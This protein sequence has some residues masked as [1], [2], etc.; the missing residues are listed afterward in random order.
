MRN[1]SALEL[2][3]LRA[4]LVD[5]R[6]RLQAAVQAGIRFKGQND[7]LIRFLSG[8]AHHGD[9]ELVV[10]EA[11]VQAAADA[12][13]LRFTL[14]PA[15]GPAGEKLLVLRMVPKVPDANPDQAPSPESPAEPVAHV[16]P[17]PKGPR[18]VLPP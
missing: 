10:D 1:P 8:L 9:G 4:D 13:Q 11:W 5:A 17:G 16:R 3:V 2:D 12:T 14:A 18:L 15:A 6:A 7:I